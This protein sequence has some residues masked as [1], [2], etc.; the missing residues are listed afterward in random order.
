MNTS[1]REFLA[2]LGA[3]GLGATFVDRVYASMKYDRNA[4]LDLFA[5]RAEQTKARVEAGIELNRKG[6]M[7]LL[8]EDASGRPAE[9]ARVRIVQKTH[10][11]RYGANLFMLDEFT[12]E[13]EKNE[14]YKKLF[15]SAFNLATVPF[16]WDGIE[17]E[18]GKLRFA[19]DS[20]KIY[21]RPPPDLCIDWCERNGI[22]PK[23]HILN[24][25]QTAPGWTK[26]SI[27]REKTLLE[28]RMREIAERY[29]SRVPMWEVTNE[30]FRDPS[31]DNGGG[32]FRPTNL[33]LEDDFVEWSF[34]TA[35]KYFGANE[36]VINE[37]QERCWPAYSAWFLRNRS[38][39]YM[40]IERAILKGARIDG[41]GMQ[42][43]M[44]CGAEESVRHTRPYYDPQALFDVLDTYAALGK[45]MQITEMTIPAYSDDPGDEEVQAEIIRQ[46]YSI[47]FSH[48]AMKAIVYWN[49]PDGYAA[50]APRGD[51]SK[52]ENR[53]RAG[54]IR[55][56][57]SP[58]P[59]YE[60]I[61]DLFAKTWRTNIVREVP[62]RYAFRGFRGAYEVE[63]TWKGKTVRKGFTI[64]RSSHDRCVV[65][66]S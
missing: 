22:E 29:A 45:P 17:P 62:S 27:F 9:G 19:A 57:M 43:H 15:A 61:R 65:R 3:L 33:Y 2:G 1:R 60:V 26:G 54:L 46:L 40:Q 35:E 11:F 52:G 53:F 30:T 41:I 58:K 59:A 39:Y 16:Y 21:R 49:L 51:Y 47:W 12:D 34:K 42:F 8:F 44:F 25:A 66:F 56:D 64:G 28:K 31:R 10:E 50:W 55:Y 38:P 24:Y 13:P 37:G 18:P 5:M 6:P 32:L 4:I 63:A 7:L 20:K 14:S 23:A 36:L 48:R